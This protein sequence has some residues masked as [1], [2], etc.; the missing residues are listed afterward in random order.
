MQADTLSHVSPS[1]TQRR[2]KRDYWE[3]EREKLVAALMQRI[4]RPEDS[5]ALRDLL[6]MELPEILKVVLRNHAK[7][8]VRKEKPLALQTNR[9]YELEDAE[10]RGQFRRLRDSLA[11]RIVFDSAELKPVLTF[12]VRLQFDL[13]VRPRAFL[14][15]LLYQH[16][17]ERARE[18]VLIIVMGFH[19]ARDFVATLIDRINGYSSG[20]LPKEVFSDICRQ[21][22]REVY[23]RNAVAL[24][25]ADIRT[26][27]LYCQ[28]ILGLDAPSEVFDNQVILAMLNERHLTELAESLLPEF[29]KKESWLAGEIQERLQEYEAKAG[30][31]IDEKEN[32]A[33]EID[34]DNFWEEAAGEIENQLVQTSL[35]ELRS[36]RM[37]EAEVNP[38]HAE[39][40]A[41]QTAATPVI[42]VAENNQERLAALTDAPLKKRPLIRFEEEEPVMVS[43]AKLEQQPSGPFPALAKLIDDKN[44][45]LFLKSIF[46]RD[47]DAYEDFIQ[48]LELIQTWKEAKTL[49]DGELNRR[50]IN[51]YTK[52]AIRFSDVIFGRYFAKR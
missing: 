17:K 2:T 46:Q 20:V 22:E 50:K 52:E 33:A 10:V 9:R 26:Y 30:S 49:F 29:A 1:G 38:G 41:N 24:F 14:E 42:K 34:I 25:M 23:G 47:E 37:T 39:A 18:D 19:D 5:I 8:L 45:K 36:A 28:R 16:A 27:Q 40:G 51:P 31:G 13:I 3:M 4:A 43:R 35:R 21:V 11:E 32:K 48:R 12:G 15:S 44:R 6:A 7:S